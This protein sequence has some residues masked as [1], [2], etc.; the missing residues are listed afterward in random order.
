LR[1]KIN[2]LPI[3]FDIFVDLFSDNCWFLYNGWMKSFKQT[4]ANE[5]KPL[6]TVLDLF[7][8]NIINYIL[9]IDCIKIV[10]LKA[11]L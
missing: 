11:A 8:D 9:T 4:A 5:F 6:E 1:D 10:Y 3:I 2:N 7:V